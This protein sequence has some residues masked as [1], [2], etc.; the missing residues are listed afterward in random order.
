[1]PCHASLGI[2][3]GEGERNDAGLRYTGPLAR[4]QYAQDRGIRPVHIRIA[5][6]VDLEAQA[7]EGT[8]TLHLR[9]VAPE[10]ARVVLDAVDLEVRSV[11]DASGTECAFHRGAEI[12]DIRL[13]RPLSAGEETT[14]DVRYRARRPRL[15]L[16]FVTP[17]EARPHRKRQMWSQG[18]DN[19]SRHWFP[20]LDQPNQKATS[21][22]IATVPA[23]F[24]AVS[25]GRLVKRSE[26]ART[27]HRTFHWHQSVPHSAYL[28]SL[29]VAEFCEVVEDWN[30]LP[31]V[32]YVPAGR[33]ADARRAF[34]NTRRMLDFFSE[35]T[36]VRY[37][38]EKY[39]HVCVEDFVFVGMENTSATTITDTTLHDDRAHLDF[40]SD[41]LVSHELAHQWFGDLVTCQDWKDAWLNEGFATYAEALWRE[42]D[43]G[44]DEFR[45]GMLRIR[46]V[47]LEEAGR[48]RRAVVTNVY[49][50]PIDLFDRHLYEKGACVL[51]MIRARIGEAGFWQA[52]RAY[53]QRHRG[54]EAETG[55]WIRAVEEVSGWNPRPLF[56]QW[57]FAP[58]HPE[59]ETSWSWDESR[60]TGTLRLKQMQ[61]ELL[62]GRPFTFHGEIEAGL[63]GGAL[64]FAFEMDRA[65][66]SFDFQLPEA[67]QWI[68]IDPQGALLATWKFP[69]PLE[70]LAPLLDHA[71]V[72]ARADAVTELARLG[73]VAAVEALSNTLRGDRFWGVQADAAAALGRIGSPEARDALIGA[74]SVR[75]PKARR[76][77]AEALG[78]FRD[79][80]AAT[81]L[82]ALLLKGDPSYYVEAQCARSLG[83]CEPGPDAARVLDVALGRESHNEVVRT[84][85]L[86]GIASC[87]DADR[88]DLLRS[89]TEPARPSQARLGAIAALAEFGRRHYALRDGVRRRLETLL[90]E[91]SFRIRLASIA[92]LETLGDPAA[93]AT[94]QA[95]SDRGAV[96]PR[97]RRLARAAAGRLREGHDKGDDFRRLREEVHRLYAE[98]AAMR[99]RIERMESSHPRRTLRHPRRRRA[100]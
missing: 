53:L 3:E 92:A 73:T 42:H 66:Q 27:G 52:V 60:R 98:H 86:A 23:S 7:I 79:P 15:G 64:T 34:G 85:A 74:L 2:L 97:V 50:E 17:D 61:A 63:P 84:G 10:V 100:R 28:V 24:T 67:P 51:H 1:M 57:I 68:R 81:A 33:E 35:K 95:L 72:A 56:D 93:A 14:L 36:G 40:S 25:N 75:H 82:S 99:E 71:D 96:E 8:C 76:A 55:D 11:R 65:E 69:R 26:D 77:V 94:L 88:L 21:E 54:A 18:Q 19:D 80:K 13:P 41:P 31:L 6:E 87:G 89:W 47:Y 59:L 38:Y 78:S 4:P 45:Y 37:P 44:T 62:K 22:V 9:A 30:G 39:A 48:Y 5:V 32:H 46:R 91:D 43:L 12:L 49:E 16:Y 70:M 90:A 29:A 20:C 58:G 83:L